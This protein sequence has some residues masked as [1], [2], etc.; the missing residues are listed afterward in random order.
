M[1]LKKGSYLKTFFIKD[2]KMSGEQ[3][4]L[5]AGHIVSGQG[6]NDRTSQELGR[7]ATDFLRRNGCRADGRSEAEVD[8]GQRKLEAEIWV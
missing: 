3:L 8:P 2:E 7:L 1:L 4:G 6:L 5:L